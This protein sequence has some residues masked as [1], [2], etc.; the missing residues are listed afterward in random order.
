VAAWIGGVVLID[1]YPLGWIREAVN[2]VLP[3]TVLGAFP[4][5]RGWLH[6]FDDVFG[7]AL[8]AFSEEIVFRRCARHVLR[9]YVGDGAAMSLATAVLFG[10]YHWWTGLGNIAEAFVMGVLLMMLYR[11]SGALWPAIVAHYLTDIADF[12][13]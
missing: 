3:A 1:H 2:G 6:V 12:A 5:S 11:R 7:L 13:F 9:R 10:A 4:H 8:V